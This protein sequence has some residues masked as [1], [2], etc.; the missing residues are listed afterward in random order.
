MYFLFVSDTITV[1]LQLFLQVS[2]PT[3]M[4]LHL[5][6]PDYYK[7]EQSEEKIQSLDDKKTKL[8]P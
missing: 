4:D 3:E 7:Q 6:D 2:P 5:L 1:F 8:W